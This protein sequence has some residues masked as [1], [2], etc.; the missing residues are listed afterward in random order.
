MH[1]S[2]ISSGFARVQPCLSAAISCQT[3]KAAVAIAQIE[4]VGIGLV[5][6]TRAHAPDCVEA[7]RL[8]HIQRAQDQRIQYTEDD[9]VCANGQCQRQNG[10]G[11]KARRFAQPAESKAQILYK[12]HISSG[13]TARA[14]AMARRFHP[15]VFSR[16]RLRP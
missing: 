15:S 4:I 16:R 9:S 11:S 8:R 13:W 7:I 3:I 5:S 6:G 12:S 10:H 14:E 2:T 1:S